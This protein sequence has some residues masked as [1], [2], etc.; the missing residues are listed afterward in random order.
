MKN[1]RFPV[2]FTSAYL[3]LYTVLAQY[4]ATQFIVP[5]L[6]ALSPFLVIWMVYC[7]LKFGEESKKT[8]EDSFYEDADM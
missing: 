3:L 8:F 6:F 1:I 5:L 4:E 2:Y 7:V